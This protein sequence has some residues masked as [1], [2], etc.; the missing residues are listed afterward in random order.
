MKNLDFELLEKKRRE[1][2]NK[3]K[4]LSSL[5][6]N[7]KAWEKI[8]EEIYTTLPLKTDVIIDDSTLREGVQMAG[9]LSPHPTD[10]CRIACM[11]RDIGVERIEVMMY[12]KPDQE[13]I[14]LMKDEGLGDMLAGWCRADPADID[15]ALKM[16]LKQIGI[17]HPVS[18]LHFEKWSETP[19]A[20]LVE[21]VVKAVEYAHDHGLTIFV[22][23]EDSTRADWEFEKIF[24]N[25][26][27][28][29]GAMVYRICDTV[30]CGFSDPE[31][32][33]PQGIPA[34]IRK[35]KEETKIKYVEIHAH[36]DLGNAVENTMA[37]IR[38]ASGIYDKIYASTT[39]LGVGE[40]S[41]NAETEKVIMN[42]Y[43]H[44][45][46]KK[47]N[48]T[49]FRDLALF[50]SSAIGFNLP[51]NKAMV[52]DAAFAHESGIHLHGIRIMPLTYEIFP[53]ELVGQERTIVIGRRS[54][55]HGI[56]LKLEQI[57]KQTV[58][59][60]DPRLAQLVEI[61]RKKFVE[62]RR[63]F[64]LKDEEFRML[65]HKVGFPVE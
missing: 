58:D 9:L 24:I 40:R 65:A 62:G 10:A 11:L 33:L 60:N 15:I 31:A 12:N 43:M 16:D 36:D 61:I 38:A 55:K 44:Y 26:V 5:E 20:T 13:G 51:I 59:D 56:K 42:C 4:G 64:P 45:G 7:L 37:A 54:G 63:R 57:L 29:A 19:L 22:H 52:G 48:T 1:I 32:P 28:D 23:G 39:F 34:K 41:G 30:G 27:A 3:V 14:K 21:R 8:K 49:L 53:P 47:W 17:S 46:I 35:I 18:Y 50:L 2:V 25:A 6:F